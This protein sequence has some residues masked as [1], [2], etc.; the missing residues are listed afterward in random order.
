[1][2]DVRSPAEYA[3]VDIP[4]SHNV[5]LDQLAEHRTEL[6][7]LDAPIVL[8]CRS[9]NCARQAEV[10]LDEMDAPRLHILDGGVAAWVQAG[11]LVS[12]GRSIWTIERQVRRITGALILPGTLRSLLVW[13]PLIYSSMLMVTGLL[14]A[15]V[16]DTCTMGTLLMKLPV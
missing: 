1:V 6:R 9:G 13:Q 14:F 4:G 8:V 7:A 10:L 5:P 2:L 12:P 15:A 3:S 11:L 16:T